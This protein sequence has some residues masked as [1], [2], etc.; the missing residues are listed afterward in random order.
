[1]ESNP[2]VPRPVYCMSIM[3]DNDNDDDDDKDDCGAIGVINVWQRNG[4]ARR[5]GPVPLGP[6]HLTCPSIDSRAP[7]SRACDKPPEPRQYPHVA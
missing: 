1:M 6:P 7:L 3:I 4:N 5:S 2:L